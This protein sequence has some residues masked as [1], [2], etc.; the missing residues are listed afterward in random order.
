M[1]LAAVL[2]GLAMSAVATAVAV[3]LAGG[4]PVR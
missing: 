2:F 4:F 1:V 3:E